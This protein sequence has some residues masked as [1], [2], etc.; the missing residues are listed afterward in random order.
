MWGGGN[1]WVIKK[2]WPLFNGI[3]VRKDPSSGNFEGWGMPYSAIDGIGN[4][5]CC[6][7]SVGSESSLGVGGE[8]EGE[9]GA[10]EGATDS[11]GNG[12]CGW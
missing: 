3:F 2:D 1:M 10:I 4:G 8:E 5:R 9:Y 6:G 7:N 12:F 11:D